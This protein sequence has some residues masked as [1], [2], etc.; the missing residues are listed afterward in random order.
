MRQDDHHAPGAAPTGGRILFGGRDVHALGG[1]ELRAYRRA[2]QPVFQDPY[3]SLNPRLPIRTIVGE[4]LR[5]TQPYLSTRVAVMYL[6]QIVETA[7]SD[8]LYARPL[9]PYT[10]ALLS[11]ALPARPDDARD[12]VI[13]EGEV[14]SAFNPPRAAGSIRGAR[15]RCRCA[16]RAHR[17]SASA[18]AA[19]PSSEPATAA[20][21]PAP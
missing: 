18:S 19:I 8:E 1:E 10:Q 2:V 7:R 5:Q 15:T 12:E 6:G 13:V 21:I 17:R 4:P 20:I 16:P 14:P 11:N 9:H 3:S